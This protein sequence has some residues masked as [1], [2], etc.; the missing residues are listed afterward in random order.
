MTEIEIKGV[1]YRCGRMDAKKQF[2]VARRLAPLLAGLGGA[3]KG[4]AAG[5]TELISPIADALSKMSDKDTDYVIDTCLLVVQR[6]QGDAWQSVTA[7][8]GSLMF[9]DIDLPALLQLTVAVIQQ[10]L[11]S[12]FPAGPSTS[13]A[14]A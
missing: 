4:D 7:R 12:F 9:D 1:N 5:F 6:R 2:H 10:N 14:A 13:T 11:G 8:D 3:I